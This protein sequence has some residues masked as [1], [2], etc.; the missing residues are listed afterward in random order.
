MGVTN[1]EARLRVAVIIGSTRQ[2][3]VGGTIGAWLV[4]RVRRR[5]DLEPAVVDL[6]D[7]DFPASYPERPTPQMT[8]FA[9]RIGQ[10][11]AFVV[12]TPEYNHSFPASLKQAIDYAY[13]E[14]HAKPVGF[15]SYGFRSFGLYAVEQLR[16]I[17][18]ELHMVTMR[19]SV[20]VDLLAGEPGECHERAATAMLDQLNWWGRALRTARDERPYVS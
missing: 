17:F 6:A 3:R 9:A 16:V 15:V 13:D 4:D 12:V 18:T 10:A 2:G 5:D 7:F 19:D 1:V 11:E 20:G 8:E 14:W